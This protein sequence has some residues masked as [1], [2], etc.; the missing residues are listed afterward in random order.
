[1]KNKNGIKLQHMTN[2]E[3]VNKAAVKKSKV[4]L[5]K[6][7]TNFIELLRM[8]EVT[9]SYFQKNVSGAENYTEDEVQRRMTRNMNLAIRYKVDRGEGVH[10]RRYYAYGN[11]RF[12]VR[13]GKVSWIRNNCPSL[14]MWYLDE[15]KKSYLNKLLKID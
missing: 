2:I 11:L 8:S 3:A 7:K 5:S 10:P 15:D 1:M 6:K 9:L 14:P 13:K 4:K 12:M